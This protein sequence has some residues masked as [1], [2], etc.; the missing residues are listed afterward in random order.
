MCDIKN[1]KSE[2]AVSCMNELDFCQWLLGF[3]QSVRLHLP[4]HFDFGSRPWKV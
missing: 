2:E 4:P 1:E 3:F